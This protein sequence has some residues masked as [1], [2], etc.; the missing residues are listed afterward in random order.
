MT[1]AE[2]KEQ[3]LN[4]GE[5]IKAFIPFFEYDERIELFAFT[6]NDMQAYEAQLCKKF[7]EYLKCE[8]PTYRVGTIQTY[9]AVKS[10]LKQPI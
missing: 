1:A 10:F 7:L 6:P 8:M 2:I 9:L 4:R 3:A 5:V